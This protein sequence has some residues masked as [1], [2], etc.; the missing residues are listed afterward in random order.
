MTE[1]ADLEE[2]LRALEGVTVAPWKEGHHLICVTF[3]GKEVGHFHGQDVIDLRL[4]PKV[5]RDEGLTRAVSQEI[6]PDRTLNSRWIG[7]RFSNPSDVAHVL[8]LVQRACAL[9]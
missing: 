3:H 5:I 4:S 6:H 9:R 7:L 8:R 1:R 2:R